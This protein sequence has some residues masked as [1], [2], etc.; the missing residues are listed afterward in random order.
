MSFFSDIVEL[1]RSALDWLGRDTIGSNLA[2][3]A[4]SGLILN[5]TQKS[6]T[7]ANAQSA[8]AASTALRGQVI[9]DQARLQVT[10]DTAHAIP[11]VYGTATLGGAITHVESQN[12]S[13]LYVVFTLC[14][15][16]GTKLSDGLASSFQFDEIRINDQRVVFAAGGQVVQYTLDRSG[17]IDNSLDGLVE[18]RC[19]A[20]GSANPVRPVG[21]A[22]GGTLE[23]AW[24]FIPTWTNTDTMNNLVFAVVRLTYNSQRGVTGIPNISFQITNSMTLPGDCIQD[25]MTNTRY[26]AGIPI[27][28]IYSE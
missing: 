27:E 15:V 14:E 4:I 9:D 3:T 13:T 21:Y 20:N 10:P 16:T 19:Y 2:R 5:Q 25:Y 6:I 8:A 7:A 12:Y 1:G 28:E 11:V 17:A 18:I 22:S 24:D 23:S 26:G